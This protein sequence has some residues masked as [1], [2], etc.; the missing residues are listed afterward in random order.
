[1]QKLLQTRLFRS[2][3]FRNKVIVS[4]FALIITIMFLFPVYWLI[5]MSFKSDGEIY[6]KVL[7]YFPR[8]LSVQGWIQNFGRQDFIQALK[9]S[10]IIAVLTMVLS[11]VFGIPAAYGLGRYKNK[12]SHYVL[13]VF[14]VS[15]MLPASVM[16]TPMYLIFSKMDLLNTY[17]APSVAVA[18]ACIPFTCVTLRPYFKSI[19]TAIDDA[20][21]ID[22]C[23]AYQSFFLLMIPAIQTG[24]ITV[25]AISFLNGWND[26]LY[27]MT[28]NVKDVMRPLT[29]NIKKFQDSY[30]TRWNCIMAYGTIL[31]IPVLIIFTTLQ[32]YIVGG[33][34]SG[35]VK[36]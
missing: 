30:G 35:A 33:L 15:Q 16:L 28:F 34:T 31:I 4:F 3:E 23:N 11:L 21:R 19:P 24:I 20:A 8:E 5:Q 9:N 36:E 25:A 17:F 27:S 32:K 6:G 26:L 10:M 12:A 22:G 13:L 1:M 14:L 7:T 29:A 2:R 18:A